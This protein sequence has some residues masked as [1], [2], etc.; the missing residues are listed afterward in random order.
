MGSKG[1]DLIKQL[2][3]QKA[4]T[5]IVHDIQKNTTKVKHAKVGIK[6]GI[7]QANNLTTV[8]KLTFKI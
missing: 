4:A 6:S 8:R 3:K 5:K 7:S 2:S 1:K